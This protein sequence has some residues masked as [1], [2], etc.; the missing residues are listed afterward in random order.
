MIHVWRLLRT[1]DHW[2][3]FLQLL[4]IQTTQPVEQAVASQA[5]CQHFIQ[6]PISAAQYPEWMLLQHARDSMNVT[7]VVWVGAASRHP[8][9]PT[10]CCRLV[11]DL[12]M[13]TDTVVG[14]SLTWPWTLTPTCDMRYPG[15]DA[16]VTSPQLGGTQS[17]LQSQQTSD[18]V[19]WCSRKNECELWKEEIYSYS[20]NSSYSQLSSTSFQNCNIATIMMANNEE[21]IFYSDDDL[22]DTDLYQVNRKLIYVIYPE[23]SI[24]RAPMV[25]LDTFLVNLRAYSAVACGQ[26]QQDSQSLQITSLIIR[27]TTLLTGEREFPLME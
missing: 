19:K 24:F 11:P 21:E 7:G 15:R 1:V 12:T 3:L 13:D 23:S 2:L 10:T 6:L 4:L 26:P 16:A 8:Q 20:G 14:W 22:S 25:D 17:I 18:P 9:H 27:F 5:T